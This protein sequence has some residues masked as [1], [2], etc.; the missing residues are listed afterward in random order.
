M[1]E[2]IIKELIERDEGFSDDY[3]SVDILNI[4]HYMMTYGKWS[5]GD[6]VSLEPKIFEIFYLMLVVDI[7]NKNKQIRNKNLMI[8]S[9]NKKEELKIGD[10][11]I[12]KD[13]YHTDSTY[14]LRGTIVAERK[15]FPMRNQIFHVQTERG[16]IMVRPKNSFL[17][18]ID[19]HNIQILIC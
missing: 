14:K 10:F 7:K 9:K 2:P 15:S 6:L 8:D 19:C 18:L 1:K 12:F 4:I 13:M 11:V 3:S 17:H 5:Y 16:I